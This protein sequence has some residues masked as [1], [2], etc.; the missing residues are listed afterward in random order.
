[1]RLN[2]RSFCYYVTAGVLISVQYDTLHVDDECRVNDFWSVSSFSG[3]FYL[4]FG[5]KLCRNF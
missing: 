3:V 5:R 4:F 1:M 2:K